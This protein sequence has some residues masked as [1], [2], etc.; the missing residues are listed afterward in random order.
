MPEDGQEIKFVYI[1]PEK[2]QELLDTDSTDP[3][4]IYFV[5]ESESKS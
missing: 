5:A 2:Y 3:N 1:T 4:A